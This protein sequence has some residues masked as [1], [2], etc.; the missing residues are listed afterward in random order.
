[1]TSALIFAGAF[2]GLF[3]F[4]RFYWFLR[5]PDRTPPPGDDLVSPADG[6]VVYVH[7]VVGGEVPIAIKRRRS[8]P[9][10]ELTGL[11]P[12]GDRGL[13]IGVFMT[14][15]DV[16]VNRVPLQGRVVRGLRTRAR[17]NLA[18]ARMFT[19]I[20]VRR[21]PYETDCEHL[22]QNERHTIVIEGSRLTVAVTQIADVWASQLICNVREGDT[23]ERG[24]RF[25]MIRMGSQVDLYIP[26]A[27]RVEVACEVGQHVSAGTTILARVRGEA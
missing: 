17:R 6:F 13:L 11:A 20:L 19:N 7:E 1:M 16:H 14:S 21:R 22:V 23:V 3:T 10:E 24:A 15:L 8:I 2:L 18:M 4:F 5:D 9:L 25:G 26:D 27:A 12:L